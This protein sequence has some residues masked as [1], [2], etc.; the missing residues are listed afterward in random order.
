VNCVIYI[1]LSHRLAFTWFLARIPGLVSLKDI[2]R[3]FSVSSTSL[4]ENSCLVKPYNKN[5]SYRP[6][7]QHEVRKCFALLSVKFRNYFYYSSWNLDLFCVTRREIRKCFVFF[8]TLVFVLNFYSR[9]GY[10]KPEPQRCEEKEVYIQNCN[11][12]RLCICRKLSETSQKGES[13]SCLWEQ[14]DTVMKSQ[15]PSFLIRFS[16][17]LSE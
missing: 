6:E 11:G 12:T 4:A 17:L 16:S 1:L 15:T 8:Q 7:I 3:Q 5:R 9:F 14:V 10:R 13:L 2:I